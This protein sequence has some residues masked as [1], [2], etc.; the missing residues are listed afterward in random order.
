MTDLHAL[1]VEPL[2]AEP[3]Q[4]L[5]RWTV[6]P[7]V[8]RWIAELAG[9]ADTN[10]RC[11]LLFQ[12][13]RK[14]ADSPLFTGMGRGILAG[15]ARGDA[16]AVAVL[17]AF[18]SVDAPGEVLIDRV[19]EFSNLH[20]QADR[21]Q[22]RLD[23]G[24]PIGKPEHALLSSLN[25]LDLEYAERWKSPDPAGR[26]RDRGPAWRCRRAFGET[27][28]AL[29]RT[30]TLDADGIARF[31]R[32]ARLEL[33]ALELRASALAGTI[34]P[35][36]ARQVSQ[37]MPI[38]SSVDEDLRDM[39]RFLGQ[40]EE[41]GRA[42]LFR[43]QFP[44]VSKQLDESDER[45]FRER[46]GQESDLQLLWRL[47]RGTDRHPLPQRTLAWYV[48]RVLDVGEVLTAEGIRGRR[49]DVITAAL[50]VLEHHRD[51]TV[52]LPASPRVRDVLASASIDGVETI[53]AGVRLSLDPAAARRLALPH[54]LPVPARDEP[55]VE[56]A[57]KAQEETVK[58]LVL[59][60]IN[61]TSVLLGLLKNQKVINTPGIVRM[62][63]ERSRNMRVLDTICTA[64][65]LHSGFANKDVPL[66]LLRSPMNIPVKVLRKFVNVR[67]VSKMDLRRVERDS[68]AVRR[69]VAAEVGAYLKSLA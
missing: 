49:L 47:L 2:L 67:Y 30:G 19:R 11:G 36:S 63:V 58:D 60:N 6:P 34:N 5:E 32:L 26:V 44:S 4:G 29:H 45:R 66:A 24:E 14:Q 56:P 13:F 42:S 54:G 3:T 46:L 1:P 15:S 12:S 62:V 64:R 27:V 9:E 16:E 23:A 39:R 40:L 50:C 20:R 28:G 31:C 35:Y 33:Q 51:G 21:C 43:E 17:A 61:N 7:E 10:A 55:D 53:D 38:L 68:S 57:E 41:S 18:L 52:L 8:R 48:D 65:N 22:R 25:D 69:E 59:S 37:V